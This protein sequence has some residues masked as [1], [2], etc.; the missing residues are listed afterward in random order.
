MRKDDYPKAK[1]EL[2]FETSKLDDDGNPIIVTA[3]KVP[4]KAAEEIVDYF[5]MSQG[6]EI[7]IDEKRYNRELRRQKAINPNTKDRL[8]WVYHKL[9]QNLGKSG[10]W[11]CK[12]IGSYSLLKD[13][14]QLSNMPPL[15]Y[16]RESTPPAGVS[17]IKPAQD[18][19][20]EEPRVEIKEAWNTPNGNFHPGARKILIATHAETGEFIAS[21]EMPEDFGGEARSSL[22]REA[23]AI[24]ARKKAA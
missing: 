17:E 1:V 16:D 6:G 5:D 20:D 3:H 10:I 22:E 4:A 13:N 21:Q 24:L 8:G 11:G 12:L 14:A 23:E 18:G 7:K 15:F 19:S 9:G 2:V